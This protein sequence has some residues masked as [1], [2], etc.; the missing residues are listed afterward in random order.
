MGAAP[1]RTCIGCRGK[2]PKKTLLRFVQAPV[3]DLQADLTGKAPGRGAYIC[4]AEACIHRGIVPKKLNTHLRANLSKEAV[5]MLK[6][7]LLDLVRKEELEE[8]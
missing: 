5:A 2:F 8:V 3:G 1:T 4:R 6:Q 7:T